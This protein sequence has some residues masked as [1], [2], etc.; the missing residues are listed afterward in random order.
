MSK[1]LS[2]VAW[3]Y[4]DAQP[5]RR[6]TGDV[7]HGSPQRLHDR[8]DHARRQVTLDRTHAPGP[9]HRGHL[10]DLWVRRR[11]RGPVRQLREPARPDGPEEPARAVVPTDRADALD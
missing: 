2:A 7:Q 5:L 1:V 8:A 4:D 9:V 11:A 10:P 6:R 3:P